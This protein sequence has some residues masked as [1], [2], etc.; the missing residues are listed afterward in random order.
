[1]E[2]LE[3]LRGQA[4]KDMNVEEAEDLLQRLR[5]AFVEGV[6]KLEECAVCFEPLEEE[7]AV[8][9]RTCKHIF[10]AP[11]LNNIRNSCCPMC[12]VSYTPDDMVQKAAVQ[13]AVQNNKKK[14]VRV[15]QDIV[16]QSCKL[17]ALFELIDQMKPDEKAVIFSQWTSL[18]NIV[19]GEMQLR[20]HTFTRIDGS[21]NPQERVDSMEKFDTVRCDSMRTPRFILCSLHAC[22]TGINLERGNV[23]FMLDPWWNAAAENQAMNR[24]HRIS[25]TRPVRV[26]RM[27]MADSLEQRMLGLQKAKEMLGKGIMER[28]SQ[29][30]K[31]KA[32]ITALRDLF[33]LPENLEQDWEAY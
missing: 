11:C 21:M 16:G 31:R 8:V 32:R 2:I 30:E 26:Y 7:S 25:S 20:G 15:K 19:Q 22:G 9:L 24:I 27:V 10:C 14:I 6:E 28:L 17:N 5:G 1:M 29:A 4:N 23:C 33:E 18:L 3:R 13:K 12:R